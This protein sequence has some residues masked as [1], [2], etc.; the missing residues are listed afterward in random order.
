MGSAGAQACSAS[1]TRAASCWRCAAARL[2]VAAGWAAACE[3]WELERMAPPGSPGVECRRL[4][5]F[6]AVG[7][8]CGYVVHVVNQAWLHLCKTGSLQCMQCCL[9]DRNQTACRAKSSTILQVS[10]RIVCAMSRSNSCATPRA[11]QSCR[12]RGRGRPCE[13]LL[14][15]IRMR[16]GSGLRTACRRQ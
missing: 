3:L 11:A 12:P 14:L 6:S 10:Y 4:E 9:A 7:R 16:Q 1:M 5:L 15:G 2:C 13:Q 8:E